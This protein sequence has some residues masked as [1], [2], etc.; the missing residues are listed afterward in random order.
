MGAA[1]S[2]GPGIWPV[3]YLSRNVI[4]ITTAQ[5]DIVKLAVGQF[6]QG[7]AGHATV[8]PG[9]DGVESVGD[10]LDETEGGDSAQRHR[11]GRVGGGHGGYTFL[12]LLTAW[13]FL[14]RCDQLVLLQVQSKTGLWQACLAC[15]A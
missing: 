7:I 14:P 10:K 9:A 8:F 5:A 13:T 6:A 12:K 4:N 11:A 1:F 15:N 2:F 3:R